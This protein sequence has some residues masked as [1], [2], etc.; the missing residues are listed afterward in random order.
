MAAVVGCPGTDLEYG[1][2][3]VAVAVFLERPEPVAPAGE[4]SCSVQSIHA[5][6]NHT[7]VAE[8]AAH[9]AG[10]FEG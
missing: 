8:V 4:S 10:V 9:I 2:K 1:Q 7:V 3:K 5:L 6:V